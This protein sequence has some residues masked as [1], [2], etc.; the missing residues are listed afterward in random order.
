MFVLSEGRYSDKDYAKKKTLLNV[1]IALFEV[2][3]PNRVTKH[4]KSLL[5]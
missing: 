5:L 4:M 1:K 2:I 3:I